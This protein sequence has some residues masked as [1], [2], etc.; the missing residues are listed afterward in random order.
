MLSISP[1][2]QPPRNDWCGWRVRTELLHFLGGPRG[3]QQGPHED[4]FNKIR[5]RGASFS[6]AVCCPMA[7]E[8]FLHAET[9]ALLKK[10]EELLLAMEK[11]EADVLGDLFEGAISYGES[12]LFL[13]PDSVCS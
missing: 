7:K 13:T 5:L 4:P 2:A 12:G 3:G 8:H 11:N 6:R 1:Y 10:L 9:P